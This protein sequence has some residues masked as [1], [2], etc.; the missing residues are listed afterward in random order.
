MIITWNQTR[1]SGKRTS[2][3]RNVQSIDYTIKG[4]RS[5]VGEYLENGVETELDIGALIIEV[6]PE[7]SVKNGWQRARLYRVTVDGKYTEINPDFEFDWRK[8]F[9]SFREFVASE[10]DHC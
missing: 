8:Q 3:A 7:G 6:T 9:I 10:L 4:A 5:F 2:W 1:A